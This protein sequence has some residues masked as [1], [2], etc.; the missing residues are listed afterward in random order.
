MMQHDR[1]GAVTQVHEELVHL[2][3]ELMTGDRP[4]GGLP[5]FAQHAMLGYISRNAGCRAT[6]V[7]DSFGVHRSTVSRQLRQCADAGWVLVE[8][9]PVR[10]GRPLTLTDAGAGVLA[11]ADRERRA[12]VQDRLQDW[13]P[14]DVTAFARLLHQFRSKPP[15]ITTIEPSGDHSA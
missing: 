4:A 13:S 10:Q 2:V 5:T 15:S 7:S 11:D 12:Q 6:D 9:G 1:S 14:A 8:P 3:R